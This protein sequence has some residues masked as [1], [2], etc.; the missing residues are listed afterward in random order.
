ML[1]SLEEGFY[2]IMFLVLPLGAPTCLFQCESTC[3]IQDIK[4]MSLY[5]SLGFSFFLHESVILPKQL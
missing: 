2:A 1:L 4:D 5:T 3:E